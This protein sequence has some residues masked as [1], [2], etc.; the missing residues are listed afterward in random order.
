MNLLDNIKTKPVPTIPSNVVMSAEKR[1]ERRQ[2]RRERRNALLR[3][4]GL[5][6]DDLLLLW[7]G[8]CF[9]AAAALKWGA[10]EALGVAGMSL[11]AYA[12]IVARAGRRR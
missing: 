4:L 2:R 6:L 10:A 9:V 12:V 5:Y 1:A 7:G 11:V 8:M 3:T